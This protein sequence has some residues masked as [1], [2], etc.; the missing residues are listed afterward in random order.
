V[1]RAISQ[2]GVSTG[3]AAPSFRRHSRGRSLPLV[4][5]GSG[6]REIACKMLARQRNEAIMSDAITLTATLNRRALPAAD[7]VQLIYLL[8]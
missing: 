3:Q 2:H 6:L 1:L 7:Q 5:Y 4:A 8:V